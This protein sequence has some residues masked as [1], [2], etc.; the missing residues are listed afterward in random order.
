MSKQSKSHQSRTASPDFPGKSAV[1]IIDSVRDGENVFPDPELP[2]FGEVYGPDDERP[3]CGSDTVTRVCDNC[4]THHTIDATC[5]RWEC[6]RCYKRAVL[7]AAIRV[8][9]KLATYR[10]KYAHS[11]ELKYHRVIIVPPPDEDFSTVADPLDRFYEVCGDLLK[12]GGGVDGG[13][14]I[15]HPYRHA[16]EADLSASDLDELDDEELALIGGD[17]QGA[18]KH[19][20]PNWSDDHVPDWDETRSILSHDPHLHAYLVGDYFHLPTAEIYEETGWFIRRLEPY[21]DENN[22]VSCFDIEDLARSVMYALSHTANF[23]DRDNYR[24]FG[25]VSNEAATESQKRRAS[26]VCRDYAG[27]VIGLDTSSVTCRR[28]VSDDDEVAAQRAV[29]GSG[30]G[31]GSGSEEDPERTSCGGRLVHWRKIP[32]LIENRDWSDEIVAELEGI[33]EELAGEPPP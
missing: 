17:D 5:D 28:D 32:E 14:R 7:K 22:H 30:S 1:E 18:W 23:S 20:L 16:D 31:S 11:D 8:V 12:R 27:H 25:S 24:F 33:Y 2:G 21:G 29:S 10:D 6:P 19:T 13:V 3:T 15:P 26:S 9:S 4:G